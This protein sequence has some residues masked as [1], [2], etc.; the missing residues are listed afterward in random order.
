MVSIFP[1]N[2]ILNTH[3]KYLYVLYY[4]IFYSLALSFSAM[5]IFKTRSSCRLIR[6]ATRIVVGKGER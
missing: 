6:D 5:P 1:G 2:T 3:V 4:I